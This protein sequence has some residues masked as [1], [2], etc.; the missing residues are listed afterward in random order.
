MEDQKISIQLP[1]GQKE[2]TIRHGEAHKPIEVVPNKLEQTGTIETPSEFWQK[3]K[4][5][6]DDNECR[7]TF[8]RKLQSITLH[9]DEKD[10]Y[11]PV[12]TGKLELHPIIVQLGINDLEHQYSQG[13]LLKSLR[14]LRPYFTDPNDHVKLMKDLRNVQAKLTTIFD[15]ADDQKGNKKDFIERQLQTNM[16]FFFEMNLPVYVGQPKTVF[17][18]DLIAGYLAGELVFTLESLDLVMKEEQILDNIFKTELDKFDD[19]VRIELV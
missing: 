18:I 14:L 9:C 8:S 5:T 12:L 19:L 6:L 13:D 2:V 11:G 10:T 15:N 4:D 7:V 16:Q 3:R 1:E 17:R